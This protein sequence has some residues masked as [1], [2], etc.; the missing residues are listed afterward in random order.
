MSTYFKL[1]YIDLHMLHN[2]MNHNEPM[3]EWKSKFATKYRKMYPS[4]T[5]QIMVKKIIQGINKR[6]FHSQCLALFIY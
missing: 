1:K 6:N 4:S 2:M 5:K 3:D